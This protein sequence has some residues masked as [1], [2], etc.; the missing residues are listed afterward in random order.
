MNKLRQR[1]EE[2]LQNKSEG[3]SNLSVPDSQHLFHELQ[4]HQIELEM[5]NDEL[6]KT[7]EEFFTL[8]K[9][10]TD[11]YNFAPTGYCTLDQ[12]GQILE[13]NITFAEQLG[14]ERCN[15]INTRLYYYLVKEDRDLLYLHF[16][17]LFQTGVQTTCEVSLVQPNGCQFQVQLESRIVP[18]SVA[19]PGMSHTSITDITARKQAEQKLAKLNQELEAKIQQRT[20]ELSQANAELA[21]AA[22]LKDE[23]LANMSHELRTPL[24]TILGTSELLSDGLYGEINEKQLKAMKYI[25]NSGHHLLSLITDIL[26]LSKIEAGKMALTPENIMIGG[27]CRD[28]E[29]MLQQMA[30]KK[31]VSVLFNSDE[32]VKTIFADRRALKQILVNLLNNAIKFTPNNGKVLLKLQGDEKNKVVNMSVIDT[33]IGI[34]EHEFGNLFKPFMQIDSGLNRNHAG[35]GLGLALIYKLVELHGGS[36]HVESEVGKGSTFRVSLPWQDRSNVPTRRDE[37]SLKTVQK[38][39]KIPHAGSVILVAED[40][41][42]NIVTVQTG[43]TA[44][45]YKVIITRNGIEALE[46]AKEIKPALILMDIQMPGMDGIEAT[47]QIRADADEQ[48]AKTPIIALTALA[49]PGDKKRCLDAGANVYLSKPMNIKLLVKEIEKQ[50]P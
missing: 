18:S 23:F 5:Q 35:T 15:L 33:G 4:V 45:G 38:E 50:L 7:N 21:R 48:L 37:D 40:N 41:E 49:M 47:K 46:G 44:Y 12:K 14:V 2:I 26:D 39:L 30:L 31:Q 34:P 22:R 32:K 9:K 29:K 17:K 28:C 25:E 43:L 6:R 16:K 10:Y 3:S 8:Q 13:A 19:N 11:L 27:F 24:N 42:S 20:A 36:V 1:A